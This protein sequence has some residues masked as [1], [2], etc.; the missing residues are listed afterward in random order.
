MPQDLTETPEWSA[1]AAAFLAEHPLLGPAGDVV[2]S[3]L[4]VHPLEITTAM[5]PETAAAA[6]RE[7]SSFLLF[8]IRSALEDHSLSDDELR[9][10]RHL[11]RVFRIEEGDLL[12]HHEAE[13]AS[14]LAEEL[15]RILED[16]W[17]DPEEAL[18]KVKLQ[19][20]LGL[21]YDQ[22]L[23][24]TAPDV[25]RV[26]LELLNHVD[27]RAG[28]ESPEARA[29]FRARL[30]VI[31]SAY[32]IRNRITHSGPDS[33][34]LYLLVNPAMP[35]FV[36]VGRTGR[37]PS[38]R[39]SELSA[40]T[41]VPT[42]FELVLDVFV[43]DC[44]EAERIVHEELTTRGYR[45]AGN[46]EFFNAPLS[47][48][49]AWLMRMRE[50]MPA[51]PGASIPAATGKNLDGG[52][53][54]EACAAAA[55]ICIQSGRGDTSLL[56]RR[57]HIGYGRAARLID[58]LQNAGVLGPANGAKPRTVLVSREEARNVFPDLPEFSTPT[59]ADSSARSAS[60]RPWWRLW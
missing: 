41:G 31:D 19:E 60:A 46:R 32:G 56:Q 54:D 37:D 29:Y 4:E 16:Q 26:V 7:A 20:L 25:E 23:E 3:L 51:T 40:A 14:L 8:A 47:E 27:E 28:I 59:P 11:H 6:K 38:T 9:A 52:E 21:S 50:I 57:L 55:A 18:H 34:Y 15:S 17:I 45:V 48:A 43:S 44:V 12:E 53:W 36:K 24:L 5:Q 42:P 49:A 22:F 35:G 2:R 1:V 10:L 58:Q 13:V 30:A 39:T 33:G